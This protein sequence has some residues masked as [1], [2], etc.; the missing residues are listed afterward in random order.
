MIISDCLLAVSRGLHMA[1]GPYSGVGT[2]NAVNK[3]YKIRSI[4]RLPITTIRGSEEDT[5]HGF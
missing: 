2:K 1:V 4:N 5:L 3:I